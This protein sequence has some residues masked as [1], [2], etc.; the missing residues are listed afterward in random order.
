WLQPCL[1]KIYSHMVTF[2]GN[3]EGISQ[4][5]ASGILKGKIRVRCESA[6]A[7]LNVKHSRRQQE[8]YS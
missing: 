3:Y 5:Q 4:Y 6:D 7:F 8:D 2:W 1:L